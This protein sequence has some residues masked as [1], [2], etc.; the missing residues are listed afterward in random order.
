MSLLTPKSDPSVCRLVGS[1][2]M[3]E[4]LQSSL[5]LLVTFHPSASILQTLSLLLALLSVLAPII[6]RFYDAIIVQCIKL[7]KGGFNRKAAFFALGA[8][9]ALQTSP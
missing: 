1:Q 6:Q 5:L 9:A 7:Y 3:L 2:F 8:P 4:A